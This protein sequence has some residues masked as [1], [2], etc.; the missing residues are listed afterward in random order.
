MRTKW[1][2]GIVAVAVAL[3][4]LAGA[5]AQTAVPK[6]LSERSVKVLMDYAWSILPAKFTTPEGKVIEVDKKKP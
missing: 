2:T 1:R 4:P 6:E 3:L 5:S